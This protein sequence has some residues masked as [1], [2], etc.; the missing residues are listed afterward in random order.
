VLFAIP[1]ILSWLSLLC[2]WWW[3]ICKW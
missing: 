1:T 3:Q 2:W